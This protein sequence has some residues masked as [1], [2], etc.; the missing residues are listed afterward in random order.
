MS[1]NEIIIIVLL[2][3]INGLLAF[4]LYIK[5]KYNEKV[6]SNSHPI[7]HL[8]PYDTPRKS[9]DYRGIPRHFFGDS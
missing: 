6:D 7:T 9:R 5:S 8:N 1:P 4:F 2:I 3:I